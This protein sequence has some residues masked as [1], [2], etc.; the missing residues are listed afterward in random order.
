MVIDYLKN[1]L[2]E[3]I[4]KNGIDSEE[5]YKINVQLD[6]EVIKFYKQDKYIIGYYYQRSIKE[7]EKII[8]QENKIISFRIWNNI[9]KSQNLLSSESIQYISNTNFR[10]LCKDI[11]KMNKI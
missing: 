1:K 4:E 10:Q 2:Y 9:A 11:Y 5:T 7:L 3:S 8:K 6:E